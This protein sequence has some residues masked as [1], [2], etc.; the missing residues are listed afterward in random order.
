MAN[1]ADYEDICVAVPSQKGLLQ[2]QT[3]LR[4]FSKVLIILSMLR[5]KKVPEILQYRQIYKPN[6]ENAIM[7]K[8]SSI[9]AVILVLHFLLSS[10]G[11]GNCGFSSVSLQRRKIIFF[12]PSRTPA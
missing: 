4:N 12:R 9:G 2:T 11:T 3:H 8:N 1:L 10:A 7:K 5:K 6:T